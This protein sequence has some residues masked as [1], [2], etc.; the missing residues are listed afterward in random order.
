MTTTETFWQSPVTH[1]HYVSPD[2]YLHE[3]GSFEY[4][5]KRIIEVVS[6]HY[7]ITEQQLKSRARRRDIVL[8]RQICMYF[9][10]NKTSIGL[11]NIGKFFGGCDHTTVIHSAKTVSNLIFSDE[12][13]RQDVIHLE[14]II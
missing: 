8:P 14:G 5:V 3:A 1:C 12:K 6:S 7:G 9:I 10:R 2:E 4:T 13:V 11:R